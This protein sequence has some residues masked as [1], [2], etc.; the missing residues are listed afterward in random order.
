MPAEPASLVE[1]L[2]RLGATEDEMAS[3]KAAGR[4]PSLAVDLT[5]RSTQVLT[6]RAVATRLGMTPDQLADEAIPGEVLVDAAAG[7]AA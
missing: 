3:A 4:L 5:L 6:P 1:Y 2:E 7:E